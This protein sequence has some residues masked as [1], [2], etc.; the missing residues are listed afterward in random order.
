MIYPNDHLPE[1]V[2]IIGANGE[3]VLTTSGRVIRHAG[4]SARELATA[5]EIVETHAVL[6]TKAWE[7]I[8]DHRS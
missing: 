3:A 5:V 1:H 2:H 7:E 6:L 4:L 8:H